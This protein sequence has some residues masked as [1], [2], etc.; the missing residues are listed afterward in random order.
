MCSA[1]F[2]CADWVMFGGVTR[3]GRVKYPHVRTDPSLP[4]PS[5]LRAGLDSHLRRPASLQRRCSVLLG[6]SV[7]LV[8]S[9]QRHRDSRPECRRTYQ[10]SECDVLPPFRPPGDWFESKQQ[11]GHFDTLARQ[12]LRSWSIGERFDLWNSSRYVES[13]RSWLPMSRV[14]LSSRRSSQLPIEPERER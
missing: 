10:R 11:S 12:E 6:R 8:Y 1:L 9:D 14:S 4:E 2:T 3:N 5:I 13:W 7:D